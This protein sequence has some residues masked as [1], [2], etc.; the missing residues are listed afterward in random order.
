MN[1]QVSG[2]RAMEVAFDTRKAELEREC[3]PSGDLLEGCLSRLNA[4]MLPFLECYD[5]QAQREHSVTFLR[6]LCSDLSHKNAES[7][8]YLHGLDRK[9]MQHFIG[10]SDWNDE[11]LI[12]V[13]AKQIQTQLGTPD[14]VIVFDPSAFPKSGKQSVGVARQWCGRLGKI[15]NC[16]VGVYMAYVSER[17]HALVDGDLYLPREWTRDKK[18]MRRAGIPRAKQKFRTR[19]A[20]VLELL[21]LHGSV[22]PHAW[23][24]GDEELGRSADFRG[25]L[26]VRGEQY[27]LAV[28]CNTRFRDLESPAP[29]YTGVGR[30]PERPSRRADEF[31]KSRRAESWT[32]VEVRDGEK[33][34]LMVEAFAR[35]VETKARGAEEW[36]EE[37]LVVM[38]YKDRDSRVVKT[39]FY[40]SNAAPETSLVEFCKVAKAEHRV[41]ECFRQAKSQAGMADYEVRNWVG[42]RHHQ[43]LSLLAA[44]FL[45]RETR[46]AEKK[47]TGNHVQPSTS[48]DCIDPEKRIAMRFAPR[49]CLENHAATV[50]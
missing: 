4:F 24:T 13:L 30:P 34:P 46:R 23:I 22:L 9:A 10:E 16:Q 17:G 40:L 41:E 27:L 3:K 47:D 1:F 2:G 39:D 18:R 37:V 12:N 26:R 11:P 7:I 21:T 42:W 48:G 33:G 15:E 29:I 44:W 43:T 28:P 25:D 20:I 6:G 49:R 50:A 36:T 45:N 31:T 32:E 8:A 38:R 14:G 19:H 35:R 5:Y